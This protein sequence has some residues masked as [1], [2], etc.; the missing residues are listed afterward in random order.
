MFISNSCNCL[1]WIYLNR[2]PF[3]LCNI[4]K[5]SIFFVYIYIYNLLIYLSILIGTVLSWLTE[6]YM[7]LCIE[8]PFVFFQSDLPFLL[9][10]NRCQEG[11]GSH[12]QNMGSKTKVA[13]KIRCQHAKLIDVWM[14]K[15]KA[16]SRQTGLKVR[17]PQW[18]QLY[19]YVKVLLCESIFF[20]E[21]HNLT[22]DACP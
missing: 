21:G 1:V 7:W 2:F 12:M 16:S 6:I 11:V 4:H 10:G 22:S 19:I 15:M 5:H 3:C 17:Q 9:K 14:R 18:E 13:C 8:S 20:L